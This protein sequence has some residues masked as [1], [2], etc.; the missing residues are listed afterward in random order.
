MY[1]DEHE[2]DNETFGEHLAAEIWH[3]R[4]HEQRSVQEL[5]DLYFHDQEFDNFEMGHGHGF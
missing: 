2:F 4:K 1:G 3:Y 5:E